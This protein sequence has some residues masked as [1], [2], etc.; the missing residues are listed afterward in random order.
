MKNFALTIL[1]FGGLIMAMSESTYFPMHNLIGLCMS[2][3][4][5]LFLN[6]KTVKKS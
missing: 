5:V 1:F 3:A 4:A 2:F 6:E